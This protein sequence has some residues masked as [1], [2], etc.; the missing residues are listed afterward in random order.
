MIKADTFVLRTVSEADLCALHSKR[1][2]IGTRGSHFPIN[3]ES[4]ADI[5]RQFNED[6]YW[7]PD[8]GMLLI[9]NNQGV[10]IGDIGFFKP[11]YWNGYELGYLIY[12]ANERGK[13]VATEATR[14]VVRYLFETKLVNRIQLCIHP[15]NKA[16]CRVAEKCGFT[17]EGTAR[18]AWFNRGKH[19]SMEVYS[20]L[21]QEVID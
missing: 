1:A 20:I 9:V 7:G 18:G 11:S 10:L 8:R 14:L 6:G 4:E 16:S 15:D 3:I 19:E 13:G 5:R 21:R 17:H 12:D 2:D